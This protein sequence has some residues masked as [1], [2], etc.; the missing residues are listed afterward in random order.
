MLRGDYNCSGAR[1]KRLCTSWWMKWAPS[2]PT[3][4]QTS[5]SNS[6]SWKVFFWKKSS[7]FFFRA[8]GL[9]RRSPFCIASTRRGWRRSSIFR[10][11]VRSKSTLFR[12]STGSG[13]YIETWF[14]WHYFQDWL[15]ICQ[16][17][18][19]SNKTFSSSPPQTK[20]AIHDI[21]ATTYYL[22]NYDRSKI[23]LEVTE[24]KS[25]FNLFKWKFEITFSGPGRPR[26]P[27]ERR[28]LES[29]WFK[30]MSDDHG[31]R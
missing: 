3:G 10:R 11:P 14:I 16:K 5:T 26:L 6:F 7:D 13:L 20:M 12:W 17:S 25:V 9:S 24:H 28:R 22:E 31:S 21:V 30:G 8:C 15:S 29:L 19:L 27:F 23:N 4:D 1:V 18:K 2:P